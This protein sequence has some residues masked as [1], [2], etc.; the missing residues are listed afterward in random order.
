VSSVAATVVTALALVHQRLSELGDQWRADSSVRSV[1]TA[2]TPR[3]YATG[4]RVECYVDAELAS[5]NGVG[6]WLE[7]R[8]EGGSW[9]IESS[10]RHNTSEGEDELFGLPT[11]YAVEDDELFREL[12]GASSGVAEAA[13]QVELAGL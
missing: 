9:I 7:F 12:D 4:D 13:S 1:A 6:V 2:V 5:G 3:R 8:H 10:I 11:R